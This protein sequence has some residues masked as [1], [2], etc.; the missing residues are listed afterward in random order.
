MGLVAATRLA[1]R[2]QMCHP[3]L[4]DRTETLL[5]RLGLPAA[6]AQYAPAEV[7]A[8]MATDKKKER[9]Q[10]RFVLP[11]ALGEVVVRGDVALADVLAVLG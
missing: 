5:K 4:A 3:S 1:A 2:L 6:Y 9:G 8:A 7:V 11:R 10:I